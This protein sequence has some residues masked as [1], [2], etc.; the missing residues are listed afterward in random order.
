LAGSRGVLSVFL[1]FELL[2]RGRLQGWSGYCIC[3]CEHQTGY[4]G[5]WRD[6]ATYPTTI[7][8]RPSSM[9]GAAAK[10]MSTAVWA[11]PRFLQWHAVP[12]THPMHCP[13]TTI[14]AV[15]VGRAGRLLAW[16]APLCVFRRENSVFGV[17]VL[18][19]TTY[20]NLT[21]D[22]LLC[23]T[24]RVP[25]RQPG[26]GA[27]A[28]WAKNLGVPPLMPP[29]APCAARCAMRPHASCHPMPMRGPNEPPLPVF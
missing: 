13:T 18:A 26:A 4:R 1:A 23:K 25:Y 10:H 7:P 15:A 11:S 27:L 16:V 2:L 29:G 24:R 17:G 3:T 21:A 20:N 22:L 5:Q 9:P 19:S 28:G 8:N 12:Q 14:G 6:W